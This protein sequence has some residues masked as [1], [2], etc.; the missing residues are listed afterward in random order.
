MAEGFKERYDERMVGRNGGDAISRICL[1]VALVF[2]VLSFFVVGINPFLYV[3]TLVLG[4]AAAVYAFFR[5][6]STDVE[7][8][9]AEV[10]ALFGRGGSRGSSRTSRT[11]RDSRDAGRERRSA[12]PRR[13]PEW[14]QDPYEDNS[15][16]ESEPQGH[17]D[18]YQEQEEPFEQPFEEPASEEQPAKILVACDECGQKLSVPTGRGNIR[19]TCPR[20]SHQFTMHS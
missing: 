8:R 7:A 14:E 9:Q 1:V 2:I 12:R 4:I 10:D 16:Q 13:T 6:N 3:L 19:V 20:C 5:M 18:G 17:D 15:W 11:R